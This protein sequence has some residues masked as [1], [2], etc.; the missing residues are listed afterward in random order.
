[1]TREEFNI[2]TSDTAAGSS[3]SGPEWRRQ[4]DG[5]RETVNNSRRPPSQKPPGVG[6]SAL[7]VG[8]LVAVV[9]IIVL[10]CISL[11]VVYE[12]E[13]Q[14]VAKVDLYDVEL[15]AGE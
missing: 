7:C 2:A 14:V 12:N 15:P 13:G 9:V 1:M 6:C 8:V 3:Y 10:L 11:I 4:L 5:E